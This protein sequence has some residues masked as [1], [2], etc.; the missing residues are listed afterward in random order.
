VTR[1]AAHSRLTPSPT[2]ARR[3]PGQGG[4]TLIEMLAVVGFTALL[5]LFAVNFYLDVTR[6]GEVATEKTRSS[7]RAVAVLDRIA[8]DLEATLLVKK[9]DEVDPLFHPW[10]FLAEDRGGDEGADHLRFATRSRIPH[11]TVL[12]ESDYQVVSYSLREG[13][14]GGL[15][16]LRWSSPRL[17]EELD[18][19]FPTSELEGAVLFA[20]DLASF[21]VRF[22]DD[23]SEWK[24]EWDS[25]TLV[26][27]S[28]LPLAAEISVA[29][30]AEVAE[31]DPFQE[32]EPQVYQRQVL[33]PVRPLDLQVLLDEASGL[34][35]DSDEEEGD[36]SEEGGCV[37]VGECI[38]LNPGLYE[39]LKASNPL[40]AQS[41]DSV[42]DQCFSEYAHFVDVQVQGC[43]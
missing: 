2:L 41:I 16:L 15:E 42:R 19:S 32:E 24:S 13:D 37:T 10:V 4:F 17:P 43:E 40:L 39:E 23:S 12:H 3:G 6:A 5:M 8:R 31:D 11:S 20:E 38:A 1:H 30:L 9:P 25:S 21:G 36:S 28:E 34:G 27:S 7:R 33:L 14:D 22:M 26:D 35:S 29:I 18:R